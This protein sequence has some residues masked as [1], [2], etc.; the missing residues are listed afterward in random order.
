MEFFKDHTGKPSMKRKLAWRSFI[1][2]QIL[3]VVFIFAYVYATLS[4]KDFTVPNILEN[5]FY[6]FVGASLTFAGI[7]ISE[8]FSKLANNKTDSPK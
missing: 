6:T 8:Y 7:N 5:V 2:A 3:V 1:S 4:D